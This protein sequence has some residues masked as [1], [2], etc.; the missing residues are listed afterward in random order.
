[1]AR[2]FF[3]CLVVS[4]ICATAEQTAAA[5]PPTYESHIRPLFKV[6]CLECHGE[7]EKLRG[8]LDL[9]L[10]RL[11]IQGGDSGPAIVPGKP[12]ESLLYQRVRD[13]EMP[14]SKKKLSPAEV[15]L[16]ARW[17]AA[18]ARVERPEP[19][20]LAKGMHIAAED[21]AFWIFQPVRSPPLPR[22]RAAERVRNPIDAF[23]WPDSRSMG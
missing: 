20:S 21:R 3:L 12:A 2:L 14:P 13:G 15:E 1:M 22:V 18:G 11:A 8:S 5:A 6:Y 10:R 9:R 23:C 16:I 17:I 4:L 19:S 7:G